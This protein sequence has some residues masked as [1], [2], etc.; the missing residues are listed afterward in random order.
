MSEKKRDRT[1]SLKLAVPAVICALVMTA[2]LYLGLISL[3]GNILLTSP[4]LH[5]RAATAEDVV[6][7]QMSR[8]QTGFESLAEE[9]GF[10][11]EDLT[12]LVD[13][14]TVEE[15]DRKVVRWWTGS[16]DAGKYSEMPPFTLEGAEDALMADEAFIRT[17]DKMMLH[18]TVE[19]IVNK[20]SAIVQSSAVQ[21]RELLVGIG[22]K[23]A[24]KRMELPQIIAL[25]QSIAPLLLVCALLMAGIIALML[26][27]R[28]TLAF[29]YI[30]S[31]VSG[32]GLLMILSWA[33]LKALNLRGM[34]AESSRALELQ[35]G[36]LGNEVTLSLLGTAALLLAAGGLLMFLSQREKKA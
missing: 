29:R 33:L 18:L 2:C 34:V 36:H 17:V 23:M 10:D 8:I 1:P 19:G 6:D 20:A 25:F 21:F 30:G 28:I 5:E 24:G 9:Y 32:T 4:A 7:L 16:I 13:R 27:R 3:A 31:G 22:A 35:V 26:S 11:P 15:L 12:K 14:Q